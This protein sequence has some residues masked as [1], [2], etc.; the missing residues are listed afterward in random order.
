MHG[1]EEFLYGEGPEDG[2]GPKDRLR[3][4]GERPKGPGK[5]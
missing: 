1:C 5:G 4:K 3:V 2:E